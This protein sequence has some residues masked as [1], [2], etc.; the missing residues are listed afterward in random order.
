MAWQHP[1]HQSEL[2]LRPRA[3]P[4]GNFLDTGDILWSACVNVFFKLCFVV[5]PFLAMGALHAKRQ[6][7]VCGAV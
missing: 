3:E 4:P 1:S 2:R 7:L 6:L 5:S